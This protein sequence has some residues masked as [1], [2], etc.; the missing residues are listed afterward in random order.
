MA[1]GT[2]G[3]PCSGCKKSFETASAFVEHFVREGQLVVGCKKK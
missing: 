1:Q 2:K 3:F